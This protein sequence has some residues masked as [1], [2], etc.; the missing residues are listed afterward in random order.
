MTDFV[1]WCGES[2]YSLNVSKTKDMI[3]DLGSPLVYYYCTSIKT[4]DI[5][6]VRSN[7][8]SQMLSLFYRRFM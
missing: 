2:F 8:S 5:G 7:V 4:A 1:G 3:I 6:I